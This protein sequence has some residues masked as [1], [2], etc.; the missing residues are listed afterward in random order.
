M[1]KRAAVSIALLATLCVVPM[2]AQAAPSVI[3]TVTGV[4][5]EVPAGWEWTEFNGYNATL[6]HIATKSGEK[7]KG[8]SPNTFQIGVNKTYGNDYNS[9][10]GP[11][12]RDQQRTFANGTT[13]RWKAGI[14]F[15]LHYAFLGEATVD[16]KALSVTILDARTPRFDVSLIEAA[17]VSAVGTAQSVPESRTLYHPSVGIAVDDT[18]KSPWFRGTYSGG[19]RFNCQAD[20]NG[21]GKG[22][23]TQ[24]MVYPA[25]TFPDTRKALADITDYYKKEMRLTIG[26]VERA[27]IPGGEA[28]WT[29]QPG[30]ERPFLGVVRRDGRYFFLNVYSQSART[31]AHDALRGDILAVAKGVHAWDGK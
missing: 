23:F 31:R 27:E 11:L 5:Y 25:Q 19:I 12:D 30:S 24:I 9:G 10:W 21:C 22:G 1:Q 7:G 15:N 13:A 20:E 14:R 28:L 4:R 16:S 2:I 3:R 17:F 6:Q 18:L 8:S 26:K 29:E